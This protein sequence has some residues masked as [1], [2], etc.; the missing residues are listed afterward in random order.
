MLRIR[1]RIQIT[2]TCLPN[3]KTPKERQQ[4]M[5]MKSFPKVPHYLNTKVR[6]IGS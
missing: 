5:T 6:K 3:L 4:P 2:A 1:Q